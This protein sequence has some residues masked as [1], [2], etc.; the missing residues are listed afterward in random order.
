MEWDEKSHDNHD[1][2]YKIKI[3]KS[4]EEKFHFNFIR[5]NLGDP[6]FD[7]FKIINKKDCYHEKTYIQY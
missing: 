7:I 4:F 1:T 5:F 6:E 3:Q 2:K